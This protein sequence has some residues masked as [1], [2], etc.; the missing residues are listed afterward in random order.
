MN[1]KAKL[2]IDILRGV[3]QPIAQTKIKKCDDCSNGDQAK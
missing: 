1:K 2:E 3:A